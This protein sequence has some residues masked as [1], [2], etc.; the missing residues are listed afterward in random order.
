MIITEADY[1]D[2]V[3]RL[4]RAKE[5]ADNTKKQLKDEGYSDDEIKRLTDPAA[6]FL[7]G[8]QEE[9]DA[10]EREHPPAVDRPSTA[11]EDA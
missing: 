4:K 1:T 2:T 9:I 8:W 6:S 5:R 3:L 7:A 11:T 10:Y